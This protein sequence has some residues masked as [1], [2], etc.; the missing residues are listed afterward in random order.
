[1]PAVLESVE[2]DAWLDADGP[3]RSDLE[4]LLVP[5]ADGVLSRH[6]VDRRVNNAHNKGAD[7]LDLLEPAPIDFPLPP[8]DQGAL[9]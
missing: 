4:S 2:W 7:L 1:M 3:D 9:W 5:A 6:P 8:T